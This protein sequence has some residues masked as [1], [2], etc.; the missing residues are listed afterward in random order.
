M[1]TDTHIRPV[2]L[3]TD[4]LITITV[5]DSAMSIIEKSHPAKDSAY[6]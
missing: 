4:T 1:A 6:F 2:P 3:H 5:R